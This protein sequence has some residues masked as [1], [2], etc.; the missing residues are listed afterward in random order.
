MVTRVDR[1]QVQLEATGEGQFKAAL[2][3]AASSVREVDAAT[4][5]GR[6]SV[7]AMADA[8]RDAA[9]AA[10]ERARAT[11]EATDAARDGDKAS[12]DLSRTL[13]D[14]GVAAAVTA[15]LKQTVEA[16]AAYQSMEARLESLTGS[17]RGMQDAL[18]LS[19]AASDGTTASVLDMADA[20]ATL[21]NGGLVPTL[22]T[23]T[24][25]RNIAA[26]TGRDVSDSAGD[27]ASAVE[28]N[29]EALEKL[30]VEAHKYGDGIV[31]TFQGVTTTIEN[32]ASSILAYL[33]DIGNNGYGDAAARQAD[34]LGGS[35]DRL[36]NGAGQLADSIGD[37][38]VGAALEAVINLGTHATDVLTRFFQTGEG[39]IDQMSMRIASRI[40]GQ[41][42]PYDAA[43]AQALQQAQQRAN[44][45][46][47]RAIQIAERRKA[48]E[49]A[50]ADAVDAVMPSLQEREQADKRNAAA[51]QQLIERMRDQATTIGMSRAAAIEYTAAQ[52]AAE[53]T[54]KG[55]AA[56]IIATGKALADRVRAQDAVTASTKRSATARSEEAER[57]RELRSALA[58]TSKVYAQYM[59]ELM[60]NEEATI[61]GW[62][63][64]DRLR[65]SVDDLADSLDPAAA[66]MRKMLD[67]ELLL[68][69]AYKAGII[70]LEQYDAMLEKVFERQQDLGRKNNIAASWA[71]FTGGSEEDSE[72]T[73]EQFGSQ[74]SQVFA[75]ALVNGFDDAE[76]QLG[77]AFKQMLSAA[78]AE[79]I[80][81]KII[82][83][84][85]N[86]ANGGSVNY[87]QLGEGAVTA[88]SAYLGAEAGGGGSG[89]ASGAA[90]G[91]A[92]GGAIGAVIGAF[93][94]AP[95]AGYYIGSVLGGLIGGYVGGGSD[96]PPELDARGSG[97]RNYSSQ[98]GYAVGPYGAV[99]VTT[100]NTDLESQELAQAIVQLDATM[101]GLLTAEENRRVRDALQDFS[102]N[103]ALGAGDILAQRLNEIIAEVEPRWINFLT[104]FTDVQQK[105]EA[106]AALRGMET[107]LETIDR[108]AHQLA[109]DT[110]GQL[111]DQLDGLDEDVETAMDAFRSAWEAGNAV[112]IHNT[113]A[114][115][116]Q[117][118]VDRYNTEIQLVNDLSAALDEAQ[119]QAY[120]LKLSL[121]QRIAGITGDYGGAVSLTSD[122]MTT[123]RD[124]VTAAQSAQ[125]ALALLNQFVAV[126]DQWVSARQAQINS[127][128][129]T[130]LADIERRRAAAQVEMQ[131]QQ[132]MEQRANEARQRQLAALQEQLRLAQEW[133]SIL[134]RANA[135]QQA[136]Q[137]GASNPLSGFGRLDAINQAIAAL[138]GGA[139]V[140]TR[141][142]PE[143][144]AT[145]AGDLLALLEQRLQLI[146]SEGLFDRPSD[147]YLAQYN[148]T[149]RL[150][151]IVRRI[152]TPGAESVEEIQA[153]IAALQGQ[154]VDITGSGFSATTGLLQSLAAEEAALREEAQRQLDELNRQALEQYEWARTV[155]E[156]KED[157]RTAELRAQLEELTGG[158][159]IQEFIALRQQE[160]TELLG[161]IERN[162]RE[163]L[164]YVL[165]AEPWTN[166][167]SSPRAANGGPGGSSPDPN[168]EGSNAIIIAPT[169]HVNGT[170]LTNEQVGNVIAQEMVRLAPML[171]R[172]LAVA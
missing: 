35:W 123:L 125:Q 83:N 129:Q 115:A 47:E 58:E 11:R 53:T 4:K 155:A 150:I 8:E 133:L 135:Q 101:A 153:R 143:L 97:A 57:E 82:Q 113:A 48:V 80:D 166:G 85:A 156:D 145:Q 160:A 55:L 117:A 18:V 76:S 84:L 121:E 167:G 26:A 60:A 172:E 33:N 137:F 161:E 75:D 32:S 78:F 138:T 163:F 110:L 9:R 51:A 87:Q 54:D 131:Q 79:M 139:G 88:G 124:A 38:G 28:G 159:D 157:A 45:E 49:Q 1:L 146:Q 41:A 140:S 118:L 103:N 108:I 93:F 59:R 116:M 40:T 170:N 74:F 119:Q 50:V 46:S 34:T 64:T 15:A 69:K 36:K 112:D 171:R 5:G 66:G 142:L 151:D 14:L 106:F 19:T 70:T 27:M 105:A 132:A 13:R 164:A 126:V 3:S 77:D 30:G 144:N 148:E 61:A 25:V 122:R 42:D 21:R 147:D 2:G 130:G 44:E 100:S 120:A 56:Q 16:I 17:H 37:S 63:E 162:L 67:A 158:L 107:Q 169:I 114:T 72:R 98:E 90:T 86:G 7:L 102:V 52:Q 141:D 89:A 29:V 20:Y 96:K 165:D 168:D 62:K 68:E 43:R 73:V 128:L 95:Q 22:E 10:E 109:S 94:G 31:V 12:R 152:A 81:K 92:V 127:E 39:T 99:G 104:R 65:E 154:L 149:L 91:A 71:M 6:T 136:M 111:R 24:A 134:E 23:L